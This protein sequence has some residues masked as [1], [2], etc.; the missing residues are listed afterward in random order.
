MAFSD[1]MAAATVQEYGKE[2]S[3]KKMSA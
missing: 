1:V 3:T 2:K